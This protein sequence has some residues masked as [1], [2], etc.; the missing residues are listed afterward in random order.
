LGGVDDQQARQRFAASP[1]ARLVTVR[2]DG[3]PHVVPVTFALAGDLVYTAVDRK[4]KRHRQLARLANLRHEPRCA[5]L[6]DHY[7]ADWRA[8]WWVRADGEAMII[9]A[10]EASHPGLA[11]L[12]GRYLAYRDE[13]PDGPLICVSVTRWSGW[14]ASG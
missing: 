11:A 13:L 10:P 12:A 14:A 9:D 3:A 1:V 7:E 4:P 2:P 6:V 5:L 8:L